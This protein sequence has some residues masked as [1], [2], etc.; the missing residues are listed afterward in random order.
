MELKSSFLEHDSELTVLKASTGNRSQTNRALMGD[1]HY[2]CAASTSAG[3]AGAQEVEH[4][5][6]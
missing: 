1:S 6:C 5:V 2:G 4:I 3:L